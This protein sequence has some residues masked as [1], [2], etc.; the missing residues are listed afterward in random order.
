MNI[1][2]SKTQLAYFLTHRD[3]SEAERGLRQS[4]NASR[5]SDGSESFMDGLSDRCTTLNDDLVLNRLQ[6]AADE[7]SSGRRQ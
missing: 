7:H 6:E 2:P 4:I 1:L 5:S 3:E